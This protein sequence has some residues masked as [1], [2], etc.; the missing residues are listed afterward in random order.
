MILLGVL[1]CLNLSLKVK[2]EVLFLLCCI[3]LYCLFHYVVY[4]ITVQ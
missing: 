4:F 3:L 2:R 1:I